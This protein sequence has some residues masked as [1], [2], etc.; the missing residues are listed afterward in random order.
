MIEKMKNTYP[1]KAIMEMHPNKA[2][3][4]RWYISDMLVDNSLYDLLCVRASFI[5]EP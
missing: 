3:S 4:Q 2:S 1:N 5:I